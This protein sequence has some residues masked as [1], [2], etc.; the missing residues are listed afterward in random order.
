MEKQSDETQVI[1]TTSTNSSDT[2]G[3]F[4]RKYKN[5]MILKLEIFLIII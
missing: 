5:L 3:S 4:K 2:S 1:A